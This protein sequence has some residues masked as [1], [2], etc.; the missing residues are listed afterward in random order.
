LPTARAFADLATA[1]L[2]LDS[3]AAAASAERALEAVAQFESVGA[4][5]DASRARQLAGRAFAQAGDRDA[6][7]ES[8]DLA[9][10]AFDSF[11]SLR[12]RDQVERELRKI[13][14]HIGHRTRPGA[15]DGLGVAALTEREL[16]VA[17]LV[18]DRKT[19]NEIAAELF[20]SQKTVETH[21]RNIFNKLGVAQRA[22]VA[23][24]VEEADRLRSSA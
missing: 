9:A 7:A 12:Y 18:V 24:L 21:L 1:A 20:L 8:L 5:F 19:N 2:E 17:R 16:Q 6:A 14:R 13:G 15:G 23:R 3:G 4:V 11:G 10:A 22:A